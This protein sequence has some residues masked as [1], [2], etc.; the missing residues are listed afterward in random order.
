MSGGAGG[1]PKTQ[2]PPHIRGFPGSHPVPG[3]H[4]LQ[5]EL[6]GSPAPDPREKRR[7]ATRLTRPWPWLGLAWRRRG[8]EG[9][10]T[11]AAEPTRGQGWTRAGSLCQEGE[12]EGG[13][14]GRD[15]HKDQ[16]EAATL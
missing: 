3:T 6:A 4:L 10:R 7:S 15:T 1:Q 12:E 5:R 8:V 2:R 11:G 16:C 9:C 13:A 14:G